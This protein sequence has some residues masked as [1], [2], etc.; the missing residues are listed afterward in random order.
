MNLTPKQRE[1]LRLKY[2]G[3]C[4]YCGTALDKKWHADHLEA[5][6]RDGKWVGRTYVQLPTMSRPDLDRLDNLMPACVPCNIDKSDS[7]L[8]A[9]RKRLEASAATLLRNYSTLRHAHRFGL[10]TV[11]T[12]SVTFY[13]ERPRKR[14]PT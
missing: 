11:H 8:E 13:F 5:V 14:Q 4:A 1:A 6:R 2:G 7:S 9:W 3:H 10:I 12:P